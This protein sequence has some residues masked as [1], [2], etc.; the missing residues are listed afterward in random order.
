MNDRSIFGNLFESIAVRILP[1]SRKEQSQYDDTGTPSSLEEMQYHETSPPPESTI[2]AQ[3]L[4]EEPLLAVD[5]P[6]S[7]GETP[8]LIVIEEQI[9][10]E[11]TTS[12]EAFL[13]EEQSQEETTNSSEAISIEDQ[14]EPETA[15]PQQTPLIDENPFPS[16]EERT[17]ATRTSLN[18][19][20]FILDED[21]RGLRL[22]SVASRSAGPG[23]Q[24]SAYDIVRLAA[25][26]E[27]GILPVEQRKRCPKCDAVIS[28]GD[29]RCQWCS[30]VLDS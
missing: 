19:K 26:L 15:V 3:D 21:S 7:S 24:L 17:L 27:G 1:S 13:V 30:E 10:E 5:D 18:R 2:P 16:L 8:E 23:A 29:K 14:N 20:G 4:N 25:D 6:S 9:P 11:T 12:Q 22:S 28:P